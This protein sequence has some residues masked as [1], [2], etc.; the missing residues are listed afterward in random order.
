MH[1]I[2]RIIP[3][4]IHHMG[5]V[6][7]VLLHPLKD[8]DEDRMCISATM[9][10]MRHAFMHLVR[11]RIMVLKYPLTRIESTMMHPMKGA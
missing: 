3:A 6:T 5:R 7:S 4:R 1:S 2:R 9:R 8:Y 11:M 10:M